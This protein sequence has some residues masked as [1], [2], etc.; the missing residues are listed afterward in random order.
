MMEYLIIYFSHTG[1]NRLLA[2]DVARRLDADCC[3]IVERRRR[4][5]LTI[6]LDMMFKRRPSLEPLEKSPADYGHTVLVA[7]VWGA[8]VAHPMQTLI[9]EERGSLTSYSFI[10][11][12]GYERA[13]QLEDIEKQ[14]EQ[15]IGKSPVVVTELRVCDLLPEEDSASIKAIS[16]YR[17]SQEDIQSFTQPVS[18][19][20]E[21]VLAASPAPA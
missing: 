2:L 11:L 10:T 12:C 7:P 6:I 20:C 21:K 5:T 19:F 15:R 13:G 18:R 3:E 1:N 4:S 17:V 16:R 9:G 8:Q 14:L